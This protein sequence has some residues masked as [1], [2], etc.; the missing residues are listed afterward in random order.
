MNF[1]LSR[2]PNTQAAETVP[3]ALAAATRTTRRAFLLFPRSQTAPMCTAI[4]T[5]D[6]GNRNEN[7]PATIPSSGEL[8]S[9]VEEL[10][11]ARSLLRSILRFNLFRRKRRAP[12]DDHAFSLFPL[13]TRSPTA[14]TSSTSVQRQISNTD[15]QA[16]FSEKHEDDQTS[17]VNSNPSSCRARMASRTPPPSLNESQN[18][19][20]TDK[21]S[22]HGGHSADSKMLF[23]ETSMSM[24]GN[25]DNVPN[26]VPMKIQQSASDGGNS[27]NAARGSTKENHDMYS[28]CHE[29]DDDEVAG[30]TLSSEQ[31]N[32]ISEGV[33]HEAFTRGGYSVPNVQEISCAAVPPTRSDNDINALGEVDEIRQSLNPGIH[34]FVRGQESDVI[35]C[36]YCARGREYGS[37]PS[38]N[39]PAVSEHVHGKS[40]QKCTSTFAKRDGAQCNLRRHAKTKLIEK[41]I[42]GKAV[43]GPIIQTV[44][45]DSVTLNFK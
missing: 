24:E 36:R 43:T 25:V 30:G 8:N 12:G 31:V 27:S 5:Q 17:R 4:S 13:R 29:P 6:T 37:R 10:P 20:G 3:N 44:I 7:L 26:K 22:R 45:A 40:Q 28:K 2:N 23:T 9:D 14:S 35:T 41:V 16:K 19:Y 42:S 32:V 39:H 18:L 21:S 33:V 11:V 15:K 38:R 34:A 1:H